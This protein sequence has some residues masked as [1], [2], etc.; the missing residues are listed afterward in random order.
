[1][2]TIASRILGAQVVGARTGLLPIIGS[3]GLGCYNGYYLNMDTRT[4]TPKQYV[5]FWPA[6]LPLKY[7]KHRVSFVDGEKALEIKGTEAIAVIPSRSYEPDVS[8]SLKQA[9]EGPWGETVM[10]PL[11]VVVYGR[12]GD[13][14]GN[15]NVG[16]YSRDNDE[17]YE[18]LKQLLSTA[19][20]RTLMAKEDKGGRIERVEFHNLRAVHFVIHRI[21]GG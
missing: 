4:S 10:L 11:G 16:L 12:S 17:E 9:E 5:E 19:N 14:G 15:I 7:I 3:Q 21:L 2:G 8:L 18:W 1:L 20:L 6:L 13:K